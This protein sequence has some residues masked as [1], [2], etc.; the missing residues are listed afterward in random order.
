[1]DGMKKYFLQFDFYNKDINKFYFGVVT[2]DFNKSDL[3]ELC[4]EIIRDGCGGDIHPEDVVIKV[5]ALNNVEW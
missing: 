1:M 4:G 2:V 5:N 3:T